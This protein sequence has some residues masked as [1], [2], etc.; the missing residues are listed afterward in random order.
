MY[1]SGSTGV[2]KGVVTPHTGI[3]ALSSLQTG[4]LGLG[5]DRRVLQLVSTS[6]DTSL[7][8][9]FCALLSGATLVLAPQDTP[10]GQDLADFVRAAGVTHLAVQPAVVANLPDDSLPEGVTLTLNGDVCPPDLVRR[11]LPGRRILNGYG[12]TEATVGAAIWDCA[13]QRG[14]GTAPST[15]TVPIGTPFDGKCL[16]VLDERLLPVPPASPESC[17]SRAA[18]PAATTGAPRSPPNASSP[19]PTVSRAS[20]CTALATA[21]AGAGRERWS[22]SAGSTTR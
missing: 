1:T 16:Y 21:C 11:W 18:W 5:A 7:W 4:L 22:S 3:A 6:F 12:P 2:P 8:D 10:L 17:T 19:A 13:P 20:G 15:G 14:T 9:S